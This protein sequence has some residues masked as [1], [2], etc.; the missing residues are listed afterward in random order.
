MFKVCR[1]GQFSG[2]AVLS[3][4]LLA[5]TFSP[6]HAAQ[7][8]LLI[9]IGAYE[10]IRQLNGPQRDLPKME[11]FVREHWGFEK[12]AITILKDGEATRAKI[13][14]TIEK[15][16]IGETENGDRVV[17]YYSGHGSQLAD[18]NGDEDDGLDE[19]LSPVDTTEDG[20]N[21]ITD[22]EFGA[23]LER[24]AGRNVIVVIDS[25]H[26]GTVSRGVADITQP[27]ASND[28][29][30]TFVPKITSRGVAQP[31]YDV[32]AHRREVSFVKAEGSLQVWSAAASNQF[33]WDTPAGGVFTR[34]FIDGMSRNLADH[35]K[36][37][38]ITNSELLTYVRSKTKDYCATNPACRS[39]GFTPSLEAENKALELAAVPLGEKSDDVTDLIVQDN[40]AQIKI[41]VLPKD[42]VSSGEDIRFRV[43]SEKPGFLILLDINADG[44]VTQLVPND[45][46]A[47][48]GRSAKMSSGQPVTIPDAYYGFKFTASEPYGEGT[49]LAIVTEDK[50]NLD[51]LLDAN[52]AM[53]V[54]AKPRQYLAE[55]TAS[56]LKI[57]HDD[58]QNRAL[59]WSLAT[60][61]YTILE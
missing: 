33:S 22:D 58:E 54:V 38:I 18:E 27:T 13:L 57:W 31:V 52:R 35:N 11:A 42:H 49:L 20:R 44:E 12:S 23:L 10:N 32:K 34:H 19:T 3:A 2:A 14:D 51:S 39:F 1:A 25:C 48:H 9:G 55:L 37:G 56:L 21:Q 41:E 60:Q 29:A 59:N 26:S 5:V 47:K 50:V 61:K 24:L 30:R 53:S 43:T 7:R 28:I 8:A 17:I 4:A 36:N 6:A 16:L 46:M 15:R 45:V 40:A